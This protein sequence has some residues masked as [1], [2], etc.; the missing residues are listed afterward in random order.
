MARMIQNEDGS[1]RSKKSRGFLGKSTMTLAIILIAL[2]VGGYFLGQYFFKTHFFYNTTINGVKCDFKNEEE[3]LELI[4]DYLAQYQLT[5]HSEEGDMTLNAAQVGLAY[6]QTGDLNVLL[7]KQDVENWITE[8]FNKHVYEAMQ[9]SV[10]DD[11]MNESIQTLPC[12][13][14]ENPQK[15]KRAK[16]I[17]DDSQNAFVVQEATVGN[18]INLTPFTEAVKKS[19]LAGEAKLDLTTKEYYKQPKYTSESDKV[20]EAMKK[21][22]VFMATVVHLQDGD[23][24]IDVTKSQIHNFIKV[25][26]DYEVS[27][28]KSE[29]ESFVRYDV[30]PAMNNDESSTTIESPGSGTIYVTSNY[31]DPK[32]VNIVDERN[33]LIEDICEGKEITREPCYNKDFLYSDYAYT[34]GDTYIDISIYDQHVWVIKEGQVVIDS[35][36]VTGSVSSGHGSPT[37]IYSIKYKTTGYQSQKY[38]AY[39]NYWMPY[40]TTYGIGLH[41]ATWRGESEFGGD[42]YYEDGSHGCI[43]LPYA[44][45]QAIYNV[46]YPGYPVIVH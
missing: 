39:F 3:A 17:Y 28:K 38:N 36:C 6:E 21:I 40:D 15:S 22:D 29:V 34:I 13:K 1:L 8:S 32:I 31:D 9:T 30:W 10:N 37:G 14:P 19:V 11:K 5:I 4:N 16:I 25:T 20:K 33:Q 7:K 43:N 41:D 46:I 27:I 26:E 45:A 23:R 2:L 18:E 24:G 35:P 42:T 44:K 12:M